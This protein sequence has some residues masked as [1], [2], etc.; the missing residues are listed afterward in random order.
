MKMYEF[1]EDESFIYITAELCP[2]KEF[3]DYIIE[4]KHIPEKKAKTIFY[5]LVCA[6]RYMHDNH[7]MHR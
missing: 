7:F 6:V 1:F 5:D 3:F 4:N 2:G